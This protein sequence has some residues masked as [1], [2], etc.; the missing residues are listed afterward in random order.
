MYIIILIFIFMI[1]LFLSHE[2][3]TALAGIFLIIRHRIVLIDSKLNSNPAT[4]MVG[5]RVY[6][7]FERSY[8]RDRGTRAAYVL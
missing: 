5:R 2:Y 8:Y 3:R 4:R 1:F 6:L 7:K